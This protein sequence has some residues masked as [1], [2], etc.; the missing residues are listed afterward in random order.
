MYV[1]NDGGAST[2]CPSRSH[3]VSPARAARYTQ[4]LSNGTVNT[5]LAAAR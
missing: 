3:Y 2:E 1:P 4:L 5:K